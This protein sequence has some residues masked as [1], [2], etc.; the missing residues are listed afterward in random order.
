M[1]RNDGVEVRKERIQKV[2]QTIV[3]MLNTNKNINEF[4]LDIVLSDIEYDTGLTERRILEYASIGERKLRYIIDRE[5]N[6][7]RRI[8]ES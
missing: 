3:A 7:I 4:P 2:I 5:K 1:V 8:T 6:K